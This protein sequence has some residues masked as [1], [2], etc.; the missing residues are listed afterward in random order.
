[1]HAGRIQVWI[2]EKKAWEEHPVNI[3][4]SLN[5]LLVGNISRDSYWLD[6]V[7]NAQAMHI[8]RGDI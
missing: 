6:L 7:R 1:M 2:L 5:E 8:R 4:N 3:D